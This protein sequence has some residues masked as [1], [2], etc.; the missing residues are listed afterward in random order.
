MAFTGLLRKAVRD[1][2]RQRLGLASPEFAKLSKR[3]AR[4]HAPLQQQ[5]AGGVQRRGMVVERGGGGLLRGRLHRAV[6]RPPMCNAVP[7]P[8]FIKFTLATA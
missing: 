8:R 7:F 1:L 4:R 6:L 2:E 5:R 3:S